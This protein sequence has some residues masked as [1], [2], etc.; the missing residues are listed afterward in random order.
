MS[1]NNEQKQITF[2]VSQE[3]WDRIEREL[4]RV[5]QATGYSTTISAILRELVQTHLS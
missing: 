5:K 2:F 3:D 4:D 1:K